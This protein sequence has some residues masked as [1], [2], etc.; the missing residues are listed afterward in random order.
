M[1]LVWSGSRKDLL[2][3]KIYIT[4]VVGSWILWIEKYYVSAKSLDNRKFCNI[5]EAPNIIE[6]WHWT[7]IHMIRHKSCFLLRSNS[8]A[9]V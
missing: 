7:I 2:I 9:A 4:A 6:Y 3:A 1:F 5:K 8:S